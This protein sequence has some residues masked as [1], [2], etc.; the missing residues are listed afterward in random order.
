[1]CLEWF[2]ELYIRQG[3]HLDDFNRNFCFQDSAFIPHSA[4]QLVALTVFIIQM[5]RKSKINLGILKVRQLKKLYIVQITKIELENQGDKRS[6]GS[7]MYLFF[8]LR[9]VMLCSLTQ[10]MVVS[11]EMDKLSVKHKIHINENIPTLISKSW[12][13][14]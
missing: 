1:M 13:T 3:V 7:A 4:F 8:D 10:F 2:G 5:N 9:Q 11:W 14:S 12:W 6:P